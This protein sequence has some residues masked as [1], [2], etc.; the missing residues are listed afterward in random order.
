MQLQDMLDLSVKL[1]YLCMN[2]CHLQSDACMMCAQD[3]AADDLRVRAASLMGIWMLHQKCHGQQ[4]RRNINM[5]SILLK[6]SS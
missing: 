5:T 2:A 1:C 6:G 4:G 3:A